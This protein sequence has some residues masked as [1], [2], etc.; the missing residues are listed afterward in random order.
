MTNQTTIIETFSHH[1]VVRFPTPSIVPALYAISSQYTQFGM[2]FDPR[3]KKKRWAPLK[4][5]AIYVERGVEFRFHI[6]QYRDFMRDLERRGI[7]PSSYTLIEH[8]DYQPEKIDLPVKPNW[9]LRPEQVEAKEFITENDGRENN[10]PLLMMATGSG[11][12]GSLD[13]PIKIPGGWTLM[14]HLNPGDVITAWDGTPTI[15]TGVYPQGNKPSYRVTFEDGRSTTCCLDHLWRVSTST[16]TQWVKVIDT[17]EIARLL[18]F[19]SYRDRLYIDLP[20][21]EDGPDLEYPIDP[22]NLGVMLGD[23][24]LSST[25]I[26][27]AKLDEELFTNFKKKLPKSLKIRQYNRVSRSI[28]K[29][30]QRDPVHVYRDALKELGLMGKKSWEKHI[31]EE[32]LFGSRHQ[33]LSMVQGLLDTDG[34]VSRLNGTVSYCST[35]KALAEDMQYLIRSLGGLAKITTRYTHYTHKNEKRTGRLAYQVNIRY[36]KPSELFRLQRK[37]IRTNDD[38]QYAANLKLRIKSVEFDGYA[39]MQCISI[40]HPDHLYVANDFIVTHNTVTALV[41]TAERQHRFAVVILAGYVDKWIGD[42]VQIMDIDRKDIAVIQ[43][44]DSLIRCTNYPDSGLPIPK[45]F[46]ISLSTLN[47]WHKLYEEAR[48]HPSLEAYACRPGEFF[49]SMGIGTVIFDEVHQHPHAV[50]RAYTYLHVPKTVNLSATLLS[51]DPTLQKVQSMMFPR[52]KRFD[53]IKM[54]KY[55]T[56][57]ACVYQIADLERSRLR[58]TEWGSNTYSHTAYEKSILQNKTIRPQYLKMLLDLIGSTYVDEY[59]EGDKLIVFVAT[60]HMAEVVVDAIK[61]RWSTYDTRTYLEKDPY[62]NVID[63]DIRVSTLIGSGT[64][65]DIPNLRR[66]ILT[67]SIKS[68]NANKQVLGRLRDLKDRDT[69]FYYLYCSTIPKHVEYHHNKKELFDD[70]TK[71]QRQMFLATLYP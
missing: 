27:I 31:P 39:E 53:S 44:S 10:S 46:V 29:V 37:G 45:A 12:A 20:I 15:V 6:G 43:G 70:C 64:A 17:L 1:F 49:E 35:S 23:G 13:T 38:N 14:G 56:S 25:T 16:K 62:E 3:S 68:P 30:N 33:R 7:Y 36:K 11:K 41:A 22:Y 60:A 28:I 5:F 71:D 21:S 34:T 42:I 4:T 32:Y 57:H 54:K 48:W 65:V 9:V 8:P 66:A 18:K 63:P 61:R 19:S 26:T 24:A 55:I 59:M 2:M 51:P 67:T 47:N 52:L 40:D 69:H 58:T 50:Y